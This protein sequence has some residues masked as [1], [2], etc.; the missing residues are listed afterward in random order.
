MA[1]PILAKKLGNEEWTKNVSPYSIII[2]IKIMIM[3]DQN[4]KRS[5]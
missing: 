5:Q 3:S 4:T 1:T 2:S